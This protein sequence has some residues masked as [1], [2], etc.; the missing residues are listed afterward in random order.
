MSLLIRKLVQPKMMNQKTLRT[1]AKGEQLFVVDGKLTT[2]CYYHIR[3]VCQ[4]D[5]ISYDSRPWYC[6]TC[7]VCVDKGGGG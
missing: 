2:A 6:N 7:V 1:N 5:M 3:V 4:Y